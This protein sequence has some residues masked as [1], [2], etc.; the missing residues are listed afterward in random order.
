MCKSK[1]MVINMITSCVILNYNDSQTTAKLVSKIR[2]YNSID[3]IV[4]VDNKSTDDSYE[5]LKQY[6][7]STVYVILSPQNGGYGYGNNV[8]ILYSYEELEATHILIANPDVEFTEE[9]VN[10]LKETI[11]FNENVAITAPVMKDSSG[12]VSKTIAWRMPHLVDYVLKGSSLYYNI[13]GSKMIY[14]NKYF[15]G[16]KYSKVDIVPGSLLMVDAKVMVSYGMYDENI[17]LYCE[18]TVL[19][20]KLREAGFDTVLLLN[21]SYTHYHSTSISKTYKSFDKTKKILLSSKMCYMKNYMKIN[22]RQEILIR[23]FNILIYF[24]TELISV[25]KKLIKNVRKR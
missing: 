18:E 16:E 12:K 1:G 22:K 24:E 14:T 13:F 10:E 5:I 7:T 2:E 11:L 9:C 6:E 20:H 25:T 3:Y 8:G 21:K 23:C 15:K 4:I 17:F 19:A